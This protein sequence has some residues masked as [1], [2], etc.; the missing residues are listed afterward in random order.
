M[1]FSLW[2]VFAEA[3]QKQK[4]RSRNAEPGFAFPA[5]DGRAGCSGCTPAEP[6]PPSRDN[7]LADRCDISQMKAN[8][9]KTALV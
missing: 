5:N 6:Y 7:I 4:A 3:F 1:S 2:A 9:I 8:K